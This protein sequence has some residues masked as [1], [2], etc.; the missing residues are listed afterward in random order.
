MILFPLG[1][2]IFANLG[3]A[4]I[5]IFYVSTIISQ[6]TFSTGSIFRGGIG[7]ELVGLF[8]FNTISSVSQ[9]FSVLIY[10]SDRSCA[11]LSQHGC[12]N[13]ISCWRRK[14]RCR[15]CDYDNI[16]RN[17]LDADGYY[18]LAHGE[19]QVGL[20][21]RLHSSPYLNRLHRR[22]RLVSCRN[23]FRGIGTTGG[24]QLQPRHWPKT[25]SIGHSPTLD[26]SPH[27][28]D[29]AL[30]PSEED[31]FSV[32]PLGLYPHYT[33]HILLLCIFHRQSGTGKSEGTRL[34]L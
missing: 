24:L 11:V 7:S 17:Q 31:H 22:C 29:I 15:H 4:G 3:P 16:V 6:V 18:L 10:P 23:W 21:R 25:N 33:L 14:P 5:S 34:D 1:N 26:Y 20:H 19:V 8:I 9:C 13:H 27:L 32:F 12:D 2:P 30:Q 28:V